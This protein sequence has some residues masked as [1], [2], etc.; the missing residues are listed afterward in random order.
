MVKKDSSR[1]GAWKDVLNIISG[2]VVIAL[3]SL[4][5]ILTLI[6]FNTELG[7]FYPLINLFS[8]I[9]LIFL[10]LYV[11]RFEKWAVVLAGVYGIVMVLNNMWIYGL[12]S[13]NLFGVTLDLAY[14]LLIINWVFYKNVK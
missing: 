4:L 9:A 10:G 2:W 7:L 13:G 6:N 1:K 8:S 3:G 11:L 12:F 5:T 14:F